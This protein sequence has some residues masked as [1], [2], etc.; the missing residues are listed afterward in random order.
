MTTVYFFSTRTNKERRT[1]K[2]RGAFTGMHRALDD[3]MLARALVSPAQGLHHL[4]P[5]YFYFYYFYM[6]CGLENLGCCLKLTEA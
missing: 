6:M 3:C 2:I 1:G 4:R 5:P